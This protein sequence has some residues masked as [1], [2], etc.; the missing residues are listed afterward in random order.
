MDKDDF[1][2]RDALVKQRESGITRTL[3]GFEMRGRGIARDG[4]EVFI[5]RRARP[6]G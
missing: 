2:G 1:V 3:V 5:G 4:Y 6:A